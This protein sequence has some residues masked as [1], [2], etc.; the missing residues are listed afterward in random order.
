MPKVELPDFDEMDKLT[1]KVAKAKSRMVA[2]ERLIDIMGATY[3]QQALEDRNTWVE[4]NKPSM[5]VLQ[6]I[7]KKVG[8][9]DEHRLQ[10]ELMVRDL[11]VATEEYWLYKEQLQNNRDR[12]EVWRSQNANAR[13]GFV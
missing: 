12:I 4:G 7:Y 13:K 8:L 3:M 1:T 11:A 9:T 2:L 10:M 5:T 6:N